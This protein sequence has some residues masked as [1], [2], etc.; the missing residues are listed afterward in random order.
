MILEPERGS[1]SVD[2]LVGGGAGEKIID[3][4]LNHRFDQ[5][6][7]PNPTFNQTRLYLW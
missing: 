1:I 6:G 5:N 4:S 3:H 2:G 7:P